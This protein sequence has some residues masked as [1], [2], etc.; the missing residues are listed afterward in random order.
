MDP[1]SQHENDSFIG[2]HL[3]FSLLL[4]F[5]LLTGLPLYSQID[6]DHSN[7]QPARKND[8][9]TGKALL[10]VE[11]DTLIYYSRH[12]VKRKETLYSISN[13]YDVSTAE[14]LL[15]NPILSAG[16]RSGQIIKIPVKDPGLFN[17]SYSGTMVL[18]SL[19]EEPVVKDT[20]P[21]ETPAAVPCRSYKY[22]GET[23]HVALMLPLYL[24]D[25]EDIVV[26]DSVTPPPPQ[27]FRAFN[28][29]EFYEGARIALDSLAKEGLHVTLHVYDVSEDTYS[30]NKILGDPGFSDMD[31]IIG[32][33]F[34]KSFRTVAEFADIHHIPIVN[35]FTRRND[36]II[37]HPS[38][39]K[40]QPSFYGQLNHLLDYFTTT[41]PDANYILIHQ[42]WSEDRDTLAY[43]LNSLSARISE[44]KRISKEDLQ[45]SIQNAAASDTSFMGLMS[46]SLYT[47]GQLIPSGVFDYD[48]LDSL[49]LSNRV[50]KIYFYQDGVAGLAR[51]LSLVRKNILISVSTD[52]VFVADMMSHIQGLSQRYNIIL[53]G[54]P[55]WNDYSLEL[56]YAM[57]LHLHLFSN[58]MIDYTDEN[59][60]R[61]VTGFRYRYENEPLPE[62]HAFLGYD[63]M[64]F[65]MKA[66]KEYGPGFS[67]CLP[68]LFYPALQCGFDFHRQG[69]GGFENNYTGIFR[70]EDYRLVRVR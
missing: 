8:T 47:D 41:Y 68:Y 34:R 50:K 15:L 21:L 70:F 18:T 19:V 59:V 51:K 37:D 27:D 67:G 52:R 4:A 40:V 56:E 38:V 17:S 35:P 58:E 61:F 55:Q 57:K 24:N 29:L 11:R 13:Q 26:S 32:P 1:R 49:E 62:H 16:L 44:V 25:I 30:V 69:D 63:I 28:F 5:L 2:K 46:D 6:R 9:L 33:V 22:G 36:V 10:R 64:L 3:V 43:L 45:L 20:V 60:I 23:I 42:N 54:M 39:Y 31:L 48:P 12:T 65:F 66:I 7:Q 53:A 14:L